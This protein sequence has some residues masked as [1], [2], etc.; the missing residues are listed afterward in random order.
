MNNTVGLSGLCAFLL[1]T[2]P[3]FPADVVVNG[4]LHSR[5][6]DGL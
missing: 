2:V 4:I 5:K 1:V 6:L 3:T